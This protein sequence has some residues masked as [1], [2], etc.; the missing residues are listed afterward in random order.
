MDEDLVHAILTCVTA[1]PGLGFNRAAL[2][3]A[4]E[5]DSYLGAAMA[6][7][8]GSPEEAQDTWSRLAAEHR[9]LSEL[10]N[11][12]SADAQGSTFQRQLAGLRV[13]LRGELAQGVT[14]APP[15]AEPWNALI[16]AFRT[17]RVVK[18]S[19]PAQLGELPAPLR[20]V[21]GGSEVVCVPLVA[22]DRSIGLI[23][24]DNTFTREPIDDDRLRLLQ[25]LALLAALA[26]DNARMKAQVEH[27]AAE[28][29]RALSELETTHDRLLHN[30]RL[31]TVGSVVARVSHEIR[32]P[33]STIGGFARSLVRH[34]GK[35]ESVEQKAAII[36]AEVE[37]LEVLLKE[38][39][40]FTSPRLP[41]LAPCDLTELLRA[42]AEL[43]R[44]ELQEAGVELGLELDAELPH[45]CADRNQIEQVFLNLL[46]NAVQAT[47][48]PGAAGR[49][50]TLRSY[51]VD[52]DARIL[53]ADAG[54]G[55]RPEDRMHL[56]KPFFTTRPR[57][58]GLGLAVVKKIIDDHHG[59]IEVES[60]PGE[61]T[62]FAITLPAAEGRK[63]HAS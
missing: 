20:S 49:S 62:I 27:Q 51:A 40:D 5:D 48:D 1:G 2:F 17:R 23:V 30:E 28:L 42:F 63:W 33:L 61:G 4:S 16:E 41:R 52:G 24:A 35:R 12:S 53:F 26:L 9:S 37:K 8:P 57:G 50:I 34:P 18:A 13:P 11:R 56:F 14:A 6:I 19:D 58:T 21:F 39:L 46:Q 55:I 25:L 43:H 10:L 29:R 7:G 45:V 47:E 3:L 38:M 22:K 54:R 36:A 44:D 31:A 60:T 59:H 15:S 32:N